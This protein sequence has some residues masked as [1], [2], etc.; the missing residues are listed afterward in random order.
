MSETKTKWH[1]L[2]KG[3]APP[4]NN[5]EVLLAIIYNDFPIQAY[6]KSGRWFGS[7]ELTDYME[8][9]DSADFFR[10]CKRLYAIDDFMNLDAK[11]AMSM[12]GYWHGY[13]GDSYFS[14]IL[15]HICGD[16]DRVIVGTYIA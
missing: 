3:E 16:S 6:Y 4:N 15:V 1:W 7:R 12:N 9:I 14:G 10:Y 11:G 5:R 2:C 13:K 8:D